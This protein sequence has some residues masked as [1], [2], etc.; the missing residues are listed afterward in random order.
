LSRARAHPAK[1]TF[2]QRARRRDDRSRPS[3]TTGQVS[4]FFFF[5]PAIDAVFEMGEKFASIEILKLPI[6]IELN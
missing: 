1:E 4:E 6:K 3:D 2:T 5:L